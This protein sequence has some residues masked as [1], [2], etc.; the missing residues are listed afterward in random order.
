MPT[1]APDQGRTARKPCRP[2]DWSI[3]KA[4][5]PHAESSRFIDA[6]GVRWH[7]QDVGQGPCLLLV[8]GTG[9][10]THSW[11][12]MMS[13]LARDFRVIAPDL[14]GHGFSSQGSAATTTL[15]GMAEACAALVEALDVEPVLLVGH[16]AGAALLARMTIAR[17][18]AAAPVVSLNGAFMPWGGLVG[19]FFSPAA[20]LLSQVSLVPRLF[21]KR[22]ADPRFVERLLRD[23][24]STLP[25][26]GVAL[27]Q[28]LMCSPPHVSAALKMMAN[29]DLN[30]LLRQLA[31]MPVPLHLVACVNDRT[32]PP[33]QAERLERLLQNARVRK[34]PG[35]GHLGH[36]ERPA[37]F[38]EIVRDYL[39]AGP[40]VTDSSG[41]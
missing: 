21:A 12:G 14:P 35:L 32:V 13:D 28:R 16:S 24:G 29:W 25:A 19:Q 41:R 15:P 6:G 38:A 36:E 4:D 18:S 8:H 17:R 39:A 27:Y 40:E 11:A 3:D 31:A 23:T 37:V 30:S 2:L 1:P 34:V 20:K 33:A 26:A 9:A 5:W 22:A 10:S 7:V